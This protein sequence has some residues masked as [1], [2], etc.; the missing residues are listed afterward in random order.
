MFKSVSQNNKNQISYILSAARKYY[1]KITLVYAAFVVGLSLILPLIIKTN[2]DYAN[3]IGLNKKTTLKST[4][5]EKC[6]NYYNYLL[7]NNDKEKLLYN[8]ISYVLG[9]FSTI[10]DMK[11]LDEKSINHG[12]IS[13]SNIIFNKKDYYIIDFDETCVT[14]P[15]YDF[16]V[17]V[18]K[19]FID[20]GCINMK[21]YSKLRKEVLQKL[22][23]YDNTDFSNIVKYYL[24]KILLE[25]FPSN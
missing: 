9:I 11:I 22:D 10:K 25:K 8:D 1:R 14:T 12:D 21:K 6:N 5:K 18:V 16:A 7:L 13:K 20:N 24:C 19:N 23:C 2:I 3:I 17:I 15:L 4:L